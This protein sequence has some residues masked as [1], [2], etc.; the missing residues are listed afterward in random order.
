MGISSAFNSSVSGLATTARWSELTAGNIANASNEGFVRKDLVVQS[1]VTGGVFVTGI[2]REVDSNLNRMYRLE[3][4]GVARQEIIANELDGYS[5]QLGNPSD[6]LS[7]SGQLSQ[8]YAGFGLLSNSPGDVSLQNNVL[9]SANGLTRGLNEASNSL[10]QTR[11]NVSAGIQNDVST[12]NDR[13]ST[14]ASLN[15][16]IMVESAPTERRAILQDERAAEIDALSQLM[17]INVSQDTDG[18]LNIATGGGTQ[19]VDRDAVFQ[20]TYDPGLKTL[21]VGGTDITPGKAGA[22]G[23]SEGRLAGRFELLN[24]GIPAK[25]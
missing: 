19:L 15:A 25:S 23:F 8:L 12:V 1:S 10:A 3:V 2:S 22:R 7:I 18:N 9:A 6:T 5:F 20:V 16:Q 21:N 17:N 24:D 11:T 4:A 13:L 14:I